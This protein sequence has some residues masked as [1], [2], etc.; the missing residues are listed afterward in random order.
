MDK[1]L[2][3]CGA[4]ESLRLE[5]EGPRLGRVRPRVLLNPFALVGRASTADVPLRQAQVSL[6]HAYLQLVQGRLA[7]FDL[8][9]RGGIQ[10]ADGRPARA[11]WLDP[12]RSVGIGPFALRRVVE[13]SQF[14]VRGSQ[15]E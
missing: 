6:R 11:G 12:D 7:C 9:G 4:T 15:W 3:A 13:G 10:W 2:E 8:G 14:A 5:I 1:F